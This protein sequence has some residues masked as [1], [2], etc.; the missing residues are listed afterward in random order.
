MAA[1]KVIPGEP[2]GYDVKQVDASTPDKT[3]RGEARRSNGLP[4]I[5]GRL[6][7]PAVAVA[8]WY[9]WQLNHDLVEV[10]WWALGAALAMLIITELATFIAR[11]LASVRSP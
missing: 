11:I 9:G 6:S 5:L 1:Y 8:A 2:G 4:D 3:P 7:M 10:L